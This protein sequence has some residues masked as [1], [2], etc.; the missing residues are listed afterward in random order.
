MFEKMI[1]NRYKKRYESQKKIVLKQKEQIQ[2][3]ISEIEMLKRECEEKDELIN[4]VE[5]LRNE[6]LQDIA[7]IKSCKEEWKKLLAD[8]KKMKTIMDKN[9]CNGRWWLIRF[10]IK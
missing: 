10:L 4:C 9:I 3:L 2:S 8:M 6:L 7:D 1:E 5:P